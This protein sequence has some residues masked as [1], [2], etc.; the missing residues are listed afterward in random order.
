[1]SIEDFFSSTCKVRVRDGSDRYGEPTG[2]TLGPAKSCRFDAKIAKIGVD[3]EG[4]DILVDGFVYTLPADAPSQS[5]ELEV[6]GVNFR[7]IMVM[8]PREFADEHHAKIAVR[9]VP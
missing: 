2:Y 6:D 1:M 9:R 3:D 4:K 8:T 5:D 7:V